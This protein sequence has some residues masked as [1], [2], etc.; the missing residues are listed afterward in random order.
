MLAPRSCHDKVCR[1]P[2]VSQHTFTGFSWRRGAHLSFSSNFRF[3]LIRGFFMFLG[4][5]P[6]TLCLSPLGAVKTLGSPAAFQGFCGLG[7]SGHNLKAVSLVVLW[8]QWFSFFN[9][10]SLLRPFRVVFMWGGSS[11]LSYFTRS[12]SWFSWRF[13]FSA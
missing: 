9:V 8:H 10:V 6:H 1:V 12:L 7:A 4:Y 11:D 3:S 5:S 13:S 2:H